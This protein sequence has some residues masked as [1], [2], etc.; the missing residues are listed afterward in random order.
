MTPRLWPPGAGEHA[1]RRDHDTPETEPPV[2]EVMLRHP[3][4][5]RSDASIAQ[6]AEALNND[7]VHLVLLIEGSRLIG[8]LTRAD[9]PV[10]PTMEEAAGLALPWSSLEGRTVSPDL[11]TSQ[12]QG[13][14]Q[15]QGVRRLAVVDADGSLL[16]LVCLKRRLSGFCS[17][18]GVEAR[19]NSR[20]DA[21]STT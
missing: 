17:D 10:Q 2:R 3:K 6:A 12:I 15:A 7:H 11:A 5:L 21:A 19:T 8:T 4:T 9:L 14:L 13:L 16:G 18:A 1:D 20:G